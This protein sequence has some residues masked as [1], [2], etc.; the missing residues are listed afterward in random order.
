MALVRPVLH[1][2]SCRNK[3]SE[4]QQNM[5]FGSNRVDQLR[6]LQK[7]PMQLRLA[8]LSVNGASSASFAS[9]F[10]LV[11]KLSETSQ[12]M[13]FGSNRVDQVRSL[14]N[15]SMQLRLANLCVNGASSASF[16]STFVQ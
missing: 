1:Q 2:L 11:A 10:V 7:M 9:T 14:R 13:S 16:P 3:R 6:S 8:N 12:N 15:I 5:S 4:M